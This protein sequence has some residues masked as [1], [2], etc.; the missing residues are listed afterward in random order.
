MG[1]IETAVRQVLRLF[2]VSRS[3]GSTTLGSSSTIDAV[4]IGG[5]TTSGVRLEVNDGD[6]CVKDGD[7]TPDGNVVAGGLSFGA[8]TSG[9]PTPAANQL[10]GYDGTGGWS[11][12]VDSGGNVV[13]MA[14]DW[15]MRWWS[16]ATFSGGSADAGIGR[17]AAGVVKST[18]G[19]SGEGLFRTGTYTVATLPSAATA[20]AG[21]IAYVSNGAAGSPVL[22]FSDGT[23]WLRVDTLAAVSSS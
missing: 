2:G 16:G 21:T 11:Y 4:V 23:N 3:G 12:T 15:Q 19:S 8:A 18:N 5:A 13:T 20:G 7:D 9:T 17:S 10:R 1:R 14:S 22:A 6:L